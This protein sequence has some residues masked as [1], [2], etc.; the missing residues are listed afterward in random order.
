MYE[1]SLLS[2]P[3]NDQGHGPIHGIVHDGVSIFGNKVHLG[4]ENI[5]PN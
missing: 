4:M 5:N 2:S 3:I 1:V